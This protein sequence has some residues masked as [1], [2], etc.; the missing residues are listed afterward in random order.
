MKKFLFSLAAAAFALTAT[1]TEP[2]IFEGRRDF[3]LMPSEVSAEGESNIIRDMYI[4][5]MTRTVVIYDKNLQKKA[6]FTFPEGQEIT[7]T[8]WYEYRD[9]P[10]SPWGTRQENRVTHSAGSWE[11]DMILEFNGSEPVYISATQTFFNNDSKFEF[12]V[13]K[14]ELKDFQYETET[15]RRGG[16]D[17]CITAFDIKSQDGAT[18]MTL[19]IPDEYL[20]G[21][22]NNV[23]AIIIE[24]KKYL[25]VDF[26]TEGSTEYGEGAKLVYDIDGTSGVKAPAMVMKGSLNVHPTLPRRGETVTVDLGAAAQPGCRIAITATN[27]RNA[28]N[29]QAKAGETSVNIPTSSLSSGMYIVTVNNGTSSTEAAKIIIR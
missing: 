23:D 4:N 22:S 29:L 26:H 19:T 14:Y 27:G 1:A 20:T 18:L 28:L 12:I 24:D 6:E 25:I 7:Y 21:I 16:Q 10:N 5:D 17:L 15:Y 13:P 8:Y 11:A 9:D 3:Q 2:T